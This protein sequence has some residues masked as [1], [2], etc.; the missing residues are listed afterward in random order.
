M[1]SWK[2]GRFPAKPRS[3]DS[4]RGM[5]AQESQENNEFATKKWPLLKTREPNTW[6]L[7]TSKS[8]ESQDCSWI[9]SFLVAGH[10]S[11]VWSS[12][13]RGQHAAIRKIRE[14]K[15]WPTGLGLKYTISWVCFKLGPTY[16]A[17]QLQAT[18]NFFVGSCMYRYVC[19]YMYIY[20]CVCVCICMCIYTCI[21][22][23]ICTYIY[24]Y[25]RMYIY[26]Y[27]CVCICIC[28]SIC[29]CICVR[30]Y[31][32]KIPIIFGYVYTVLHSLPLYT[33]TYMYV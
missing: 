29:I 10:I 6:S 15:N 32:A 30:K 5:L 27:V 16:I 3:A 8:S 9:L 25:V 2:C 1:D 26:I 14:K 18:P 22:I 33:H 19:V 7:E 13:R 24:I 4:P 28:I 21:Y 20:I 11:Y 31:L 23:Y 17:T 12:I